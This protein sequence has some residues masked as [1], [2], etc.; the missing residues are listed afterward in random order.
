M[1]PLNLAIAIVAA[2]VGLA[3]AAHA[4]LYDATVSGELSDVKGIKR[5]AGEYHLWNLGEG[6]GKIPKA[7]WQSAFD[8]VGRGED[9]WL[10]C[11]PDVSA[12]K[13]WQ[14]P[15]DPA[16]APLA[17]IKETHKTIATQLEP[18]CKLAERT[19]AR[20]WLYGVLSPTYQRNESI[21]NDPA[22]WLEH[23]RQVRELKYD[24]KKTLAGLLHQTGGGIL[25]ECYFYDQW[26]R[27]DGWAIAKCVLVIERQ[28]A[29]IE[30]AG[31]RGMPLI[32]LDT[33]TLKPLHSNVFNAT[34]FA[35]T[36]RGRVAIWAGY[37]PENTGTKPLTK[38][39]KD[40]LR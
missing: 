36:R 32:R 9:V 3:G 34:Y 19:G 23:C 33:P 35:A 22:E 18:L 10:D 5:F 17:K 14:R 12:R 27:P 21:A 11:E 7:V 29:A 28:A 26:N 38:E 37:A 40:Q 16:F 6:D 25:Y 4:Q 15:V 1:K 39:Q 24:G 30:A 31:L 2:L 20:V 13:E 8:R